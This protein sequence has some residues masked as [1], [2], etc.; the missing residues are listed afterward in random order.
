MCRW[1]PAAPFASISRSRQ[2]RR[3]GRSVRLLTGSRVGW[4]PA[5]LPQGFQGRKPDNFIKLTQAEFMNSNRLTCSTEQLTD[6][7]QLIRSSAARAA[8]PVAQGPRLASAHTLTCSPETGC[9]GPDTSPAPREWS[10]AP[11]ASLTPR[12]APWEWSYRHRRPASHLARSLGMG[13]L[14]LTP[15]P[16]PG[17]GVPLGLTPSPAPWGVGCSWASHLARSLG[18]G[19]P[20]PHIL[21]PAPGRGGASPAVAEQKASASRGLI[22]HLPLTREENSEPRETLTRHL[23]DKA[24]D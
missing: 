13:V 22:N 3:S 9:Q 24:I 20:G 6:G 5:A 23:A 1:A 21:A 12:S 15:H 14:G 11:Q 8:P 7:S 4:F 10:Q 19:C 17:S 16:L 18:V 2:Q